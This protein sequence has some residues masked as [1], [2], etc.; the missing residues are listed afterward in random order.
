MN[1]L[2]IALSGAS[3]S[4]KTTF[5]ETIK[6]KY[7]DN[8]ILLNEEIRNLDIG[9]IDTIRQSPKAYL[10]LEIKIIS[11]KIEAENLINSKHNN[12]IVLCDRSLIDSYFYY[13]FYV[14]KST[15]DCDD[16]KKYH[17]FLSFLY[18][19][20]IENCNYLYNYIYFLNPIST[21]TRQ[22][23]YTQK[24]LSLTQENEYKLMQILSKGVINNK[25]KF[26]EYD[27][28]K[29]QSKMEQRIYEFTLGLK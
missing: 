28:I 5:M 12:K 19:T 1:N 29:D 3:H 18:N 13:T 26:I 15:L 14:D 25:E 8:V 16:L 6:K 22:D 11:A 4:G 9:D 2:I 23:E 17:A 20:M 27:V 10:D 24:N 21:L 7:P